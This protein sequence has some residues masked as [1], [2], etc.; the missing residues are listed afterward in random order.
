MLIGRR[1]NEYSNF[2]GKGKKKQTRKNALTWV[3][4]SATRIAH[5]VS[6]KTFPLIVQIFL[7]CF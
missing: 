5:V 4:M 6:V 7:D 1:K 2:S 3:L